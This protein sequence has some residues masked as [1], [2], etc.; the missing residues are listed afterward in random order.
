[1]RVWQWTFIL[2]FLIVCCFG[3]ESVHELGHVLAAWCSGATVERV[4]LLPISRTDTTGVEHPLFVYGAGAAFGAVFPVVL[5]LVVRLLRLKIAYLFRFFAGFCL[6]ANGAYIGADFS[7]VG[8]TDAGL[9]M[10]HG[11]NRVV[12]V[13]FGLIC[14]SSGLFLWHGQS[15]FFF[16]DRNTA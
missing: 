10:E 9:L 4:V 16:P 6:I 12:L 5:W 3:M 14:V 15:R 2:I 11:A 13:L 1:M 8:P 7:T